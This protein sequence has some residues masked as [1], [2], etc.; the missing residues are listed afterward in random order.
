MVEEGEMDPIVSLGFIL[1]ARLSRVADI[2]E[3]LSDMEG[4]RIIVSKL[5]EPRHLWIKGG[6]EFSKRRRR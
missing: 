5:G 3:V 4:V 1:K 2:R 6:E